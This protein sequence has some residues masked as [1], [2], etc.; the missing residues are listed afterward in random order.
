[1]NQEVGQ[2]GELNYVLQKEPEAGRNRLEMSA[3]DNIL[4]QG[5]MNSISVVYACDMGYV[6][7]TVVSIYSLFKNAKTKVQLYIM[8]DND[9]FEFMSSSLTKLCNH[10]EM[11]E[12]VHLV[13]LD[14][15]GNQSIIISH[16]TQSTYYRLDLP[17]LMPGV[18]R[19]IYLDGDTVVLEDLADFFQTDLTGN[20]LAGVKAAGYY[21]PPEKQQEKADLLLIDEFT[22]YVNAGVLLMNLDEIRKD[23][24]KKKW[25]GLLK[26]KLSSQD[27][28]ILNSACHGRIALLPPKFNL[29]TKYHPANQESYAEIPSV[30]LCWSKEEWRE[31]CVN[32]VVIHY[33]DRIK[34]WQNATADF[35][36]I[37]WEYA[38]E[39]EVLAGLVG[40]F[41]PVIRASAIRAAAETH[42]Y[43]RR[44]QLLRENLD[45]KVDEVERLQTDKVASQEKLKEAQEAIAQ[46]KQ[47]TIR[48]KQETA[49]AKKKIDDIHASRSW[50]VGRRITL[51]PRKVKKLFRH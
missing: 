15:Y 34:P 12:A 39:A 40:G 11:P 13:A 49:Q 14:S 4:N 27:Q 32:P 50:R 26:F 2:Q 42:E 38:D 3:K 1:M 30:S 22:D 18:D 6:L 20:Y 43:E 10:F 44:E 31:A 7:P 47:E 21:Y 45:K 41:L 48:A 29:M 51:I 28:D 19:C 33:A 37:W 35:A 36:D 17:S 16:T 8:A 25:D 23:S 5:E 9:T 46:A 24:I